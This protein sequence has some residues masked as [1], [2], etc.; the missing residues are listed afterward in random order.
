MSF[1]GIDRLAHRADL[2]IL[3][4][5]RHTSVPVVAKAP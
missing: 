2:A 3:N 1:K 5:I 4:E